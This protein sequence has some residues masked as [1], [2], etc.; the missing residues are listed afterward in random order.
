MV[1]FFY[2]SISRSNFSSVSVGCVS[3][4]KPHHYAA[5]SVGGTL[6]N[7]RPC[8]ER[9]VASELGRIIWEL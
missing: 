3:L 5:A 8:V 7:L 4:N 9:Y 2:N 6:V 1:L